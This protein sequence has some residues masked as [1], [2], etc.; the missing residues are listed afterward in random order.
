MYFCE[1][2]I[3]AETQGYGYQCVRPAKLYFLLEDMYIKD[4]LFSL[5]EMSWKQMP[6][7][8]NHMHVYKL[9]F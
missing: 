3:K 5:S 4:K 6:I 7:V 1:P 9:H 2:T 8:Y